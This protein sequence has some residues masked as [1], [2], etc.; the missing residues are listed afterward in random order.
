M[1]NNSPTIP[2][3]EAV[4]QYWLNNDGKDTIALLITQNPI[5][6]LQTIHNVLKKLEHP[7][8][9]INN[10]F[11]IVKKYCE[12]NNIQMPIIPFIVHANQVYFSGVEMDNDPIRLT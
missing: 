5:K 3:L 8:V 7:P 2:D 1:P 4:I 11:K 10:L 6:I 9:W 12:R